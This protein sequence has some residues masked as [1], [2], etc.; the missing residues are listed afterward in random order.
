MK[1]IVIVIFSDFHFKL[2]QNLSSFIQ[3]Q[4]VRGALW[5][6]YQQSILKK[7]SYEM[8]ICNTLYKITYKGTNPNKTQASGKQAS[9]KVDDKLSSNC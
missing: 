6:G 9:R 4:Y 2:R 8:L 1:V 7:H 5:V 3:V